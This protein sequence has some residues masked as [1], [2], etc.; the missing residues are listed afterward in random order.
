MN[1]DRYQ[2]NIEYS[3]NDIL[4]IDL[5][6]IKLTDRLIDFK[7]SSEY[8]PHLW[9]REMNGKPYVGMRNPLE[10]PSYMVFYVG[11]K[12]EITIRFS[13]R[14]SFYDFADKIREYGYETFDLS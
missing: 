9:E 14:E 2:E 4:G 1:D 5:T 10:D 13:T 6:G 11:W 3:N 7:E 12:K 8:F